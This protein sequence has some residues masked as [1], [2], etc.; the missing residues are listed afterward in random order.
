M[1]K[2]AAC[3]LLLALLGVLAFMQFNAAPL[4]SKAMLDS[5]VR[6]VKD[7]KGTISAE[8]E[9]ILRVQIAVADY[10]A[11]TRKAP[12]T[13][14][15]LV[16]KYFDSVPLDPRTN[17]PMEFPLDKAAVPSSE[18]LE[19]AKAVQDETILID[20]QNFLNPN[21]M[22]IDDFVYDPAGRRDPFAPFDFSGADEI[23]YALP[24][25]ERYSVGQLKLSSI[26]TAGN[27]YTAI[28]EDATGRGYTVRK[29]SR[30]GNAKGIVV[31]ITEDS[32]FVVETR[33]DFTGKT[34]RETLQM[35]IQRVNNDLDG[36]ATYNRKI[37]NKGQAEQR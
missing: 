36:Q 22:V 32:V 8:Q 21:T 16:P 34:T 26:L 33:T 5:A 17:Q 27:E 2:I 28:I 24:P 14:A 11:S 31:K 3:V 30:V 19:V 4:D 15:E 12:T 13:I 25:L 7:E 18:P 20:G 9:A 10:T 35:Q 6:Q 37:M 1:M 29:G 23:D